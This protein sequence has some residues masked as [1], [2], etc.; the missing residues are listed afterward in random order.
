MSR[1][2]LPGFGVMLVASWL[3][4]CSDSPL[5]F[6]QPTDVAVAPNGDFYVADG[7][8]HTRVARFRA[9]GTFLTQWKG[10]ELGRPWGLSMG[11][12]GFLY[13]I[14]G[15]DQSADHPRARALKLDLEGNVVAR[16]GR[17]GR[18]A[19]QFDWGHDIAVDSRGQ[20]Y[21]VDIR[22]RRVQK[23]RPVE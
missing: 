9:D 20:V 23:F 22:G 8:G 7:Y 1:R 2:L 18:E 19:G 5:V 14:D 16:W 4:G 21:V 12:D 3:G 10:P 15:G 13:V 17:H 6:D 11:R